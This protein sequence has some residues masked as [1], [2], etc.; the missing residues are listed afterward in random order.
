MTV[1]EK[2]ED[3]VLEITDVNH[4]GQGVG[5]INGFAVFVDGALIG[6]KVKIKIIKVLKNYG[7]GKLLEIQRP[8]PVRTKPFCP[9]YKRCGGCSLQHMDY[10]AQL[11][12]KTKLVKETLK[13]I[14]KINNA[15]VLVQDTIGM[16]YPLKYRN[17]AQYPVG[18]KNGR[19]VIG[20]YAK[21]SHDII[22]GGNCDIQEPVGNIIREIF[23]RFIEENKISVYDEISHKGL[24][25]HLMIRSGFRTGEIMVVIV[26]NGTDLP[27]KRN[28]V[29]SL[30]TGVP[31]IESIV[32]NIN[33]S[34][35]NV[36]LGEKNIK[37]YGKDTITDYIGNFKF[38][39]SPLSFFQ[40]N[41][42]QTEVLY[43]KALEFASLSGSETVFDL[44]CGTGTIALFMAQKAKKVYGVE[45]VEE[46]VADARNNACA[47]GVHNVEFIAGEVEKVIPEL[48]EN[49]VRAD[50]VVVDPPRKGC[51][52][53]LLET[54][55]HMGPERI[56]YV[57]CNPATLARDLMYL[58]ERGY[59]MGEVQPVD[60]FPW[61]VHTE[62]VARIERAT[63]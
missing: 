36:I 37:I 30:L 60:M 1:V 8:S 27:Q 59:R 41:P 24:I 40:V 6:E 61:T 56:V 58:E 35:T 3:Y 48:Y 50:V 53:S 29:N 51:D 43:N 14:G 15:D 54:I 25:R 11:E 28:L 22:D 62:S 19:P 4:E 10:N 13:R 16:K 32:L 57:S 42:V 63:G 5:H 39:I 55:V 31:A 21:R 38:H 2:N 44:Y 12:F 20:F 45:V 9:V 18:M 52:A 33:T 49:G 47:N 34:K 46:A 7:V 26:I 17:K 23:R